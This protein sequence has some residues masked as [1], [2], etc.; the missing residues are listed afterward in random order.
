MATLSTTDRQRV[1]RAL[2]RYWSRVAESCALTKS[3]LQAAVNAADDWTDANASSFNT[4]LPAAARTALTTEQKALLLA[5]V[6]LMRR[7]PELAARI[8]ETD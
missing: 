6:A 4:A 5:I 1:W 8:G 2:Q 3:D 7:S